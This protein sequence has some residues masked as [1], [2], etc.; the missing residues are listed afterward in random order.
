MKEPS[1]LD[2]CV[3][4]LSHCAHGFGDLDSSARKN[5]VSWS[6]CM[7]QSDCVSQHTSM[8]IPPVHVITEVLVLFDASLTQWTC[9]MSGS[10]ICLAS[11]IVHHRQN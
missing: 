11:R 4:Y 1:A 3:T 5:Y 10:Q 2:R 9:L 8:D 7:D 6:H